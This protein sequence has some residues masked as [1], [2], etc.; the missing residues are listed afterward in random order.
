MLLFCI[1]IAKHMKTNLE[2][3]SKRDALM[4]RRV[5]RGNACIEETSTSWACE[6]MASRS[7]TAEVATTMAIKTSHLLQKLQDPS[8]RHLT[9]NPSVND[10]RP[11]LNDENVTGGKETSSTA[12]AGLVMSNPNHEKNEAMKLISRASTAQWTDEQLSELFADF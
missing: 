1:S 11:S 6:R 3:Q 10:L 8:T 5:E 2:Q 12:A 7:K 4:R 9:K